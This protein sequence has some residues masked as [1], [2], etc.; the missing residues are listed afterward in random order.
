M[1]PTLLLLATLFPG[2]DQPSP[3]PVPP[4]LGKAVANLPLA[5]DP[6][7]LRG[8]TLGWSVEEVQR[9]FGAPR[10]LALDT[11]GLDRRLLTPPPAPGIHPRVLFNPEDLPALRQRL[12]SGPGTVGMAAIRAHLAAQLTGPSAKFGEVYGRLAQ[13]Q[14]A[15]L[16]TEAG[17]L[18]VYEAFRCLV[19]D[20]AVAGRRLAT[21]LATLAPS[22][23]ARITA[24][25]NKARAAATKGVLDRSQVFNEVAQE[26]VLQGGLGLAYDWTFGVMDDAQRSAVRGVLA[27][28]S[29]GMTLAG[30]DGPR[31]WPAGVTNH[32]ALE[33]RLLYV[34]TAIEG[35]AG[36]DPSTL[37]RCVDAQTTQLLNLLPDGDVYE[38]W[39]KYFLFPEHLVILGKRGHDLFPATLRAVMNQRFL[40]TEDPWGGSWT[41]TDGLTGTGGSLSRVADVV[42][43]R[44][45]FPDD[46]AGAYVLRQASGGEPA[47]LLRKVSTGH[48]GFF[49]DALM[50]TL[51]ARDL[52]PAAGE[53]EALVAGRP[54]TARSDDTG[55]L[56]TRTAWSADALVLHHLCRALPG[57]YA[58]A[59][60]SHVNLY[61]LGRPWGVYVRMRQEKGQYDPAWRS[62]LRCDGE[63]PSPMPG[64]LAAA[65]DTPWL[66]GTAVDLRPA[67][68]WQHLN[69]AP[70]PAGTALVPMP[71]TFNEY[72]LSPS[73]LPWMNLHMADLPRWDRGYRAGTATRAFWWRRP[74][75]PARAARSS[76]LVRGPHPYVLVV[77]DLRLD[78]QS[79]T[80]AWGLTIAPDL[81]GATTGGDTLLT[82]AT[83][84]RRLLVRF[85]QATPPTVQIETLS[86]P[87]P[88]Q[89]NIEVRRLTATTQAPAGDG[90]ALLWP[91]RA[92]EAAPTTTWSGP[93]LTITWPDQQDTVTLTP[94]PEGRRAIHWVRGADHAD[95]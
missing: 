35:E 82:E 18:L 37:Q 91:H 9:W 66:S 79:R 72:R 80:Y 24:A 88:P 92:G 62:V 63:G 84:D 48:Y 7:R 56:I 23:A 13:G 85:L 41:F 5:P 51:F 47:K 70:A 43:Y 87:N 45:L 12:T 1:A 32:I 8:Q 74:W 44:A 73:P 30:A 10:N 6:E 28:A 75:T 38:S 78:D 94:T 57:G 89:K 71:G 4:W 49:T 58:Y 11:T 3:T 39:G 65:V 95:L 68:T 34:V 26:A 33:N 2:A 52:P 55:N 36:Y 83:G 60:R 69:V 81:T 27:Q 31:A 19:D 61:A 25:Q 16:P 20:D 67:W 64:H 46:R 15:N 53:R 54:L 14:V 22:M 42:V 86:V 77:D 40:V 29:A 93:S 76:L 21:A 50:M 90:V 17:H 59:D